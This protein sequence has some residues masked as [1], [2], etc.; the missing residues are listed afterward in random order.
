MTATEPRPESPCR[1]STHCRIAGGCEKCQPEQWRTFRAE[2]RGREGTYHG[3]SFEYARAGVREIANHL[4]YL[5]SDLLTAHV[6]GFRLYS[7]GEDGTIYLCKGR[8]KR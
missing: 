5:A 3:H 4:H 2:L 1:S 6:D 8:V 7:V